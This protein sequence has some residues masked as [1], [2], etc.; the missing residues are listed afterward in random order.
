M[1]FSVTLRFSLFLG[2]LGRLRRYLPTA[3][4]PVQRDLIELKPARGTAR[5]WDY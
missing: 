3:R 1:T 2:L 4:E 5:R